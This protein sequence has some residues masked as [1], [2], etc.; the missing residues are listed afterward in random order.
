MDVNLSY[1]V[2]SNTLTMSFVGAVLTSILAVAVTAMFYIRVRNTSTE[3]SE[4]T[5]EEPASKE[6]TDEMTYFCKDKDT[7]SEVPHFKVHKAETLISAGLTEEQKKVEEEAR[8]K[9]LAEIF[10]LMQNQQ[11]KFGMTS[12]D[13]VVEQMKLYR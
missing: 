11:E 7:C 2:N 8:K 5:Q 4:P 13:D 3:E 12:M 9:Q 1:L 6:E 10:K